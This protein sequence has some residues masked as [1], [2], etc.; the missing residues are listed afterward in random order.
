M[1]TISRRDNT[2]IMRIGSNGEEDDRTESDCGHCIFVAVE[3][4]YICVCTV[5]T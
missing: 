3:D 1:R 5:R 4:I 2:Y